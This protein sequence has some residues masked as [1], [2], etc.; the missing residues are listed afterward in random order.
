MRC[1]GPCPVH[2]EKRLSHYLRPFS[3]RND[4]EGLAG[5]KSDK[6]KEYYV[7]PA[8]VPLLLEDS[9]KDTQSRSGKI[10]LSVHELF[11]D[12]AFAH[13]RH[14]NCWSRGCLINP[15]FTW[16]FMSYHTWPCKLTVKWFFLAHISL[17][18]QYK[19]HH[20]NVVC[21]FQISFLKGGI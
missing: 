18:I 5:A 11:T 19:R 13:W 3:T 6:N 2:D 12:K 14:F 17:S 1:I 8:H 21:I 4:T 10:I 7:L 20:V 16:I 9:N 15:K